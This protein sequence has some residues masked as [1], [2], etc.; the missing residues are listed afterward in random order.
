[1]D[2]VDTDLDDRTLLARAAAG[3]SEAV[4]LLYR[5]HHPALRRFARALTASP[6]AAE[7]VAHDAFAVLLTSLDRFDPDRSGLPSYLYGV[8]RNLMRDR[9]RRDRRLLSVDVAT[10]ERLAGPCGLEPFERIERAAAARALRAAIRGL[11]R[12]HR[13]A[14][15]LCELEGLSQGRAA[16]R[17]GVTLGTLRARLHLGR[18][19][20]RRRL[21]R[22]PSLDTSR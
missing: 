18:Q 10:V 3:E 11:P 15:E 4:A 12:T 17:L 16:A 14:V 6:E 2:T 1:M 19:L 7:D 22:R 8:V 20:L 5:R 9:A 13:T 21:A